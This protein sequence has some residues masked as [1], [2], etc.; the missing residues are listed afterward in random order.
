VNTNLAE[1]KVALDSVPTI[2]PVDGEINSPFGV[3]MHPRKKVYRLHRGVD[4]T[5]PFGSPVRAAAYGVVESATSNRSYGMLITIS[6]GNGIHTKYA[7]NSRMLVKKGDVVAKG[8]EI[9]KVGRSGFTT[10]AHCHYEVLLDRT[11]VNPE[12]F[13]IDK[14]K[15]PD[16]HSPK[17]VYVEGSDLLGI[18]KNS[19][20]NRSL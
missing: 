6:H 2:L 3:R 4:I 17:Q 1:R 10:G 11:P 18:R 8:Q 14:T 20:L 19:L 7:H 15:M 9:A 12:L 13:V 5:A 16:R